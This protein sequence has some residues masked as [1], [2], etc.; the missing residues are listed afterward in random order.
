MARR[1]RLGRINSPDA[2]HDKLF[3][4]KLERETNKEEDTL[5]ANRSVCRDRALAL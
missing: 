5:L 3:W 4:S 2:K 1:G